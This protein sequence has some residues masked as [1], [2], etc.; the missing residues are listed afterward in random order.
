MTEAWKTAVASNRSSQ[1]YTQALRRATVG[2]QVV[3]WYAWHHLILGILQYR[4][5]GFD[6]A[7]ASAQRAIELQKSRAPDA[8]AVRAMAYYR[9]H[10]V[11]EAQQE[12]SLARQAAGLAKGA[13]DPDPYLLEEAAALLASQKGGVGS[14]R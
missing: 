13:D 2:T 9:L 10:N 11:A 14:Q 12:L 5:G 7:L 6:Q 3:P 4:T 8:H 1:E